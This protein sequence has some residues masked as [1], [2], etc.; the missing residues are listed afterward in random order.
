MVPQSSLLV[1]LVDVID[2]IPS[3]PRQARRGTQGGRPPVYPERL[4]LKALIIMLVRNVSTVSG[5]LAMLEQP[6]WEMW[7]LR[8]RLTEH[9]RFPSR[10][11]W[12]RRLATLPSTLPARIG[13]LGRHLVGLIAP[14]A[15]GGSAV[16]VDSTVL[17]ARGGVW[18]KKH[19][20][21]GVVPHTSIDTEAGWTKSGWH[22]W[23]YGW[24]LHLATTV[25]AVWIPLAAELTPANTAD[26]E[27][28]PRLLDEL[29]TDVRF[30][31]G[32]TH[33]NDPAVRDHCTAAGRFLVATRRGRYPH[34]DDGVEVRR[35]FH[36]LR[37]H[38]I[39]N[40]NGQFKGI[41]DAHG[42]VPTRGLVRTQRFALGAVLLYQ[43]ALLYRFEHGQDL[44]VGL[45]AFLKAA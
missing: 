8:T 31:L 37:S 21:A 34:T 25:A 10:R 11:T 38:A 35:I 5:L 45:K 18:H 7:A 6:T 2:A 39:E 44:R 1:A 16:A 13:C 33:Y 15:A 27:P 43:L 17:H 26:N 3:P 22:G 12:E 40:F 4:F 28:A 41:F 19:R 24:K 30:V 23:V 32:D 9:G 20:D 29:P 36:Q 14:W 42:S